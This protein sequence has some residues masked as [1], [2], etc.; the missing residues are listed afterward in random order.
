LVA[1]LFVAVPLA[2]IKFI[3]PDPNAPPTAQEQAEATMREAKA[4]YER[5]EGKFGEAAKRLLEAE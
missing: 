5:G 4:A 3:V 2:L 1:K